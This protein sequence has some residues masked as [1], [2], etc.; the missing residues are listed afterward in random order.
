MI[1]FSIPALNDVACGRALSS[2]LKPAAIAA[3]LVM[4]WGCQSAAVSRG[5]EWAAHG[6]M[7]PGPVGESEIIGFYPDRE[8][9]E[10]AASEW[11]ARQVA[12]NPVFADCY[13]V[14]RT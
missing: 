8:T 7:A 11:M 12:G 10:R 13:P 6:Y 9:C 14:D 1:F 4:A 5:E 2:G 3:G